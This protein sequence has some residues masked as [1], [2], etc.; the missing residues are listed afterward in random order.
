MTSIA[1]KIAMFKERTKCKNQNCGTY[2]TISVPQSYMEN[3]ETNKR[4]YSARC[5]KCNA[6]FKLRET[7]LEFFSEHFGEPKFIAKPDT[8]NSLFDEE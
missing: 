7:E 3:V 8:F 2:V 6:S 4:T 5:T 1:A